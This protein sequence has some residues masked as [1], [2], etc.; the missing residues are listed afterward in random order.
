MR[1]R[2]GRGGG[3]HGE[4]A[5]AAGRRLAPSRSSSARAP[6]VDGG[7]RANGPGW[8]RGRRR[9]RRRA[10]RPPHR[11]GRGHAHAQGRGGPNGP[12]QGHG[13]AMSCASV[14]LARRRR[15]RGRGRGRVRRRDGR[16]AP[17]SRRPRP[18]DVSRV[19]AARRRRLRSRGARA[20]QRRHREDPLRRLRGRRE[21]GRRRRGGRRARAPRVGRPLRRGGPSLGTLGT[22]GTRHVAPRG[23]GTT[24][25]ASSTR[26]RG[27]RDVGGGGL[28][29]RGASRLRVGRRAVRRAEP[30]REG[31]YATCSGWRDRCCCVRRCTAAGASGGRGGLWRRC[32]RAGTDVGASDGDEEPGRGRRND[33]GRVPHGWDR[34]GRVRAALAPPWARCGARRW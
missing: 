9:R 7:A 33:V 20:A 17:V 23:G 31:D 28:P 21:G 30:T 6:G 22:L 14:P 12:R 27:S 5:R 11:V 2:G 13:G 34:R 4:C 19:C 15:R 1:G 18:P 25:R 3:A 16:G 8:S 24:P 32:G 29:L 26:R 10:R